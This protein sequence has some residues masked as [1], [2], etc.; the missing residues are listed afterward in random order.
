MLAS[1]VSAIEQA[2]TLLPGWV[3]WTGPLAFLLWI[4][5]LSFVTSA[6]VRGLGLRSVR[7]LR[8]SHWTERARAAY[9]VQAAFGVLLV[10]LPTVL[11]SLVFLFVGPVSPIPA[12]PV[13]IS[14]WLVAFLI[15]ARH[16]AA[17]LAE[18]RRIELS[19][20]T[21]LL[22]FVIA[23]LVIAPAVPAAVVLLIAE[24]HVDS[25]AARSLWL[26]LV[27]ATIGVC[28]VG[29]SLLLA[30]RLGLARLA[31]EHVTKLV[32]AAGE[33]AGH[34]PK[35]VYVLPWTMVNAFA[36]PLVDRIAFTSAAV[37]LLSDAEL[38]AVTRHEIGHLTEAWHVR[39]MRFALAMLWTPLIA[40]LGFR[41]RLASTAL[42]LVLAV[43]LTWLLGLRLHHRMEER[44]DRIAKT[45]ERAPGQY[46]RALERL[47]E[48]NLM[49][50]V[51]GG[52]RMHPNLYDRLLAA[53][54]T[55]AYERPAKPSGLKARLLGWGALLLTVGVAYAS[56]WPLSLI[57]T[58]RSETG[59]FL[60]IALGGGPYS[61]GELAL[62]RAASRRERDALILYRAEFELGGTY[63]LH[64]AALARLE[65]QLGNCDEARRVLEDSDLEGRERVFGELLERTRRAV[66]DC[67]PRTNEDAQSA[68][69]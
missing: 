65:A 63:P 61:L 42:P 46:A 12:L 29:Y 16:Y 2:R 50:A 33:R 53:G 66:A 49:P 47:Y 6:C 18:I 44:A 41:E 34:V 60:E 69:Q 14:G 37:D 15:V 59:L 38:E 7:R 56:I 45:D 51:M 1:T 21:W 17:V 48:L 5:G 11:A 8:E 32:K 3:G 55:P 39:W 13:A 22:G 4:A 52:L 62:Y 25:R 26:I 36:L 35:A 54:E 64:V 40:I 30:R 20:G 57:S 67:Q 28:S 10:A 19:L 27:F 24:A 43:L 58:Q 9:P 31:P 23:L 68:S